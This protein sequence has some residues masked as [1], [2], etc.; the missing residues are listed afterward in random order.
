M[1]AGYGKEGTHEVHAVCSTDGPCNLRRTQ[2]S[3]SHR[4]KQRTLSADAGRIAEARRLGG[5]GG[6]R[7]V[8]YDGASL[9]FRGI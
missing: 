1:G 3:A 2:E 9:S 6:V 8:F 7:R 4:L 5:A